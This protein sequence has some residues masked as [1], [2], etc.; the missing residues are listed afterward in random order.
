MIKKEKAEWNMAQRKKRE[1]EGALSQG[2]RAPSPP[3]TG[4]GEPDP[5]ERLGRAPKLGVGR[6]EEP[7]EGHIYWPSFSSHVIWEVWERIP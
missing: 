1:G 4:V 6:S 3:G 5:Q 7:R 2:P